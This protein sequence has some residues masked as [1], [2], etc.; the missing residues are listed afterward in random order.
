MTD[1]I[2]WGLFLAAAVLLT[3]V[4]AYGWRIHQILLRMEQM[5]E[6]ATER[7]FQAH[8]YEETRLSKLEHKLAR[9]FSANALSHQKLD[10]ERRQIKELIGDISH[11]TKTP[12]ANLLLYTQLLEEQPL[13]EE[14]Q[15]LVQQIAQQSE[16][17]NFLIGALVKLSRLESGIIQVYPVM[18]PLEM[19]LERLQQEFQ[20]KAKQQGIVLAFHQTEK[21]QACFDFKWTVE[22]VGNLIEN[23]IKYTAPNGT[24]TVMVQSL[25]M[26]CR[27]DVTDTGIGIGEAELA[28]VFQRFYRGQNAAGQEGVGIGLYLARQI[29]MM[30]HGYIKAASHPG[31]GSTFSVYLPCRCIKA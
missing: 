17:L 14:S 21:L 8:T 18:Q 4:L 13:P 15:R 9:Y 29:I 3:C 5:V 24:V 16:K 27:I 12:I 26:F 28:N 25:E 22:A 23:A 6:E 10:M 31:N 1:W 7:R 20:P 19:L 30:E 11:Q 2:L